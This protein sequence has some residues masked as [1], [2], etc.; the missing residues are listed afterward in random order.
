MINNAT[1]N[2]APGTHRISISEVKKV[3][4]L[5]IVRST[6]V[7]ILKENCTINQPVPAKNPPTT[8]KGMNRTSFPSLNFPRM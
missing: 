6:S 8:G 7:I 4:R 2:T 1:A 5:L 3:E